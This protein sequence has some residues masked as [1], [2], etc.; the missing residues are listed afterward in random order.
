M[1][2]HLKQAALKSEYDLICKTISEC[3]GN[4][5]RAAKRLGID[6][7]TL[8]NKINAYKTILKTP[9]THESTTH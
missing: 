5:S 4:K 9:Q 2:K 3:E 1:V 7:K 8:Y 6:R